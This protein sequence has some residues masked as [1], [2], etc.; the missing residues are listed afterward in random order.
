MG[1]EDGLSEDYRETL[2]NYAMRDLLGS[3]KGRYIMDTL[4]EN[5]PLTHSHIMLEAERRLQS[6]PELTEDP[7][8]GI[9]YLE[10]LQVDRARAAMGEKE[11]GLEDMLG[12]PATARISGSG[13]LLESV[14]VAD[15]HDRF[16]LEFD[17][18]TRIVCANRRAP[19]TIELRQA[20][21]VSSPENTVIVGP[22]YELNAYAHERSSTPCSVTMSP[23]ARMGLAYARHELP[24]RACSLSIACYDA[25]EGWVELETTYPGIGEAGTATAAISHFARFA[26]M[27]RMP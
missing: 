15:A 21:S 24:E 19:Q 4:R 20:E 1:L 27:A 14:V 8:K 22:V 9:Q 16:M 6:L 11:H 10:E 23:P 26:L 5:D 3:D 12:R 18:G 25:D 7:R 13:E 17:K 2:I